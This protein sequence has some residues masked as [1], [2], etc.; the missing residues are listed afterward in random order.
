MKLPARK[1]LDLLF[2]FFTKR[3]LLVA[4]GLCWLWVSGLA[5]A[6]LES[7]QRQ[8]LDTLCEQYLGTLPPKPASESMN[9]EWLRRLA[10]KMGEQL[11][12]QGLERASAKDLAALALLLAQV[13][14]SAE[15][16]S[17][18]PTPPPGF[19]FSFGPQREQMPPPPPPQAGDVLKGQEGIRQAQEKL[20]QLPITERLV[21]TGDVASVLQTTNVSH[22]PDL[23]STSGRVRVNFVLRAIA[24]DPSRGLG[25]GFFFLQM[26]AAGG[27]VD[28]SAVGGPATFSALN[29]IATDRSR[30]NEST[31]RG[32]L[33]LSKAYY[34]QALQLGDALLTARGGVLDLSDYFDTNLFANNEARQFLNSALVNSAGY[35]TGISTPGLVAAYQRKMGGDWLESIV[36][37]GGFAVS[38]TERAFTS[39]LWTGELE[40]QTRFGGYDGHWRWGG[41]AGNRA[42]FG[43]IHGVYLSLDQ[44]LTSRTGVFARYAISSSGPG[45][46]SF[47]TARQSYSGGLQLRFMDAQER[48]S[49]WSIGFSQTFGIAT[50]EVQVSERILETYY[51]WQWTQHISLTPDFQLILG[52]GGRRSRAIQPVFGM[53]MNLGF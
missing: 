33:Y 27:A 16:S 30:F 40:L 34:E 36:I 41:T 10:G 8:L 18:N 7:W 43:S 24:G 9:Q 51:R 4:S 2:S 17:M 22:A 44:W 28:S 29:D 13:Q 15:P 12:S 23:T 50:D 3:T 5:A 31:S 11:A 26:R 42:G 38:R 19:S 25:D 1:Q 14:S 48:A 21:L 46:Q 6:G 20:A 53:R 35:K 39:P 32:N 45:S 37:R 52:S 49:A 47:G